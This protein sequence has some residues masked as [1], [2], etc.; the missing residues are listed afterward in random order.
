VDTPNEKA[1]GPRGCREPIVNRISSEVVT[2]LWGLILPFFKM[3]KILEHW[4]EACPA[5]MYS[6]LMNWEAHVKPITLVLQP[7]ILHSIF[8]FISLKIQQQTKGFK[9]FFHSILCSNPIWC[10]FETLFSLVKKERKVQLQLKPRKKE[11]ILKQ[12]HYKAKVF[13]NWQVTIP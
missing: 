4:G 8:F 12:T 3:R 10:N 5:L 6:G 1:V 2:E 9:V 13:W 7:T 11:N